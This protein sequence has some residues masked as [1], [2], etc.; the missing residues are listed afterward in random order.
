MIFPM[1]SLEKYDNLG[2]R[3]VNI[4]CHGHKCNI[5]YISQKNVL[6]H[7]LDIHVLLAVVQ[8]EIKSNDRATGI[9]PLNP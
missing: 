5:L 8:S 1:L 2:T 3:V 7:G 9:F 6:V 4:I